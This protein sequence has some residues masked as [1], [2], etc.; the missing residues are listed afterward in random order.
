MHRSREDAAVQ[1][2]SLRKMRANAYRQRVKALG[3]PRPYRCQY[4]DAWH[5]GHEPRPVR[6][7]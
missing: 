2:A 4:C 6:P 5:L 7:S 1:L 3:E